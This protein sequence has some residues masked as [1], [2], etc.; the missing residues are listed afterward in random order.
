L[1]ISIQETLFERDNP[2][3]SNGVVLHKNFA[4]REEDLSKFLNLLEAN[5]NVVVRAGESMG[6]T[7][8]LAEFARRHS[9]DFEFA[10][11]DIYGMISQTHLLQTMTNELISSYRARD[12]TLDPAGWEIL[13]STRLKLAVLQSEYLATS[14]F[15]DIRTLAPPTK[16]DIEIPDNVRKKIEIRMCPDCGKPLKWIEKYA[17]HYCYGCRKYLPR[18]R[19]IRDAL[20]EHEAYL[21]KTCPSCGQETSFNEKYSHY[22]CA[23]CKKYPFVHLRRRD[24][25]EFTSS[26]LTEVLELPQRIAHKKGVRVVVMFD[27]FQNIT[28]FGSKEL[29]TTMRSRFE[30]HKGV[31]YVFAGGDGQAMHDIFDDPA[32]PFYKFA[33]TI[34]LGPIPADEMEKFLMGRFASAGGKLPRGLA[35]KIVALSG[36][37]PGHAQRIAHELFH[38]SKEPSQEDMDKAIRSVIEDQSSI[39]KSIWEMIHSPLQKRYLIA[40]VTEPLAPHG[41]DFI[42]RYGLKSRSHAQRAETQLEA[43][44]I[45]RDGEIMDPLFVL[46]LRSITDQI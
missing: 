14:A 16:K 38:F 31:H 30:S 6:K 9:K 28:S 34:D 10:Y 21:D 45:T 29:L 8:F 15:D 39:Y 13:R 44:G 35:R 19:K 37:Y 22:Y 36:N 42:K 25:E 20:L 33:D 27:E 18:Q 43:K 11:I 23:K 41:K 5:K 2:F 46:W 24:P 32:G 1:T 12:G 26:D 4:G 3:L 17:R 7:S 40:S